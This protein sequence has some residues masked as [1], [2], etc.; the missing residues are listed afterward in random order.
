MKFS[1]LA[2]NWGEGPWGSSKTNKPK[3]VGGKSTARG[4][5]DGPAKGELEDVLNLLKSR[6]SGGYGRG[7]N[8]GGFGEGWIIEPMWIALGVFTLWLLSGLY[9]VAPEQA[10]VVT[11]FGAYNR[12]TEPGLHYRLPAPFEAVAKPMV[13]RENVLEVGFRTGG[14]RFGS[15]TLD[16]LEESLMLTGDEN[17]VDLDFT[18]RWK[19]GDPASYLFNVMDPE[20]TLAASA[21]SV[22]REVIGRH[23]IDD[24]LTD[25]KV[26]LQGE[27]R[28][29]LQTVLDSYKSG[30]LVTGVELQQVNPPADV[31]ESFRDVQAARADA[32]KVINESTGYANQIVPQARGAAEQMLAEARAYKD[33]TLTRAEGEAGRFEAQLRGY[34]VAPEVTRERIYFDMARE[35]LQ[36]V[37]KV[38]ISGDSTGVLPYLPLEKLMPKGGR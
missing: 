12:T 8:G 37:P 16:V 5:T 10:G 21:E 6:M 31:I 25:N 23:P 13:T 26:V 9:I 32:E 35:I 3:T 19:I 38:V 24:A 36:G 1:D 11:R 7:G 20:T 28:E 17:I 2:F 4:G 29:L 34:R 33:A 18:V 22:M 30:I 14:G 27:A 15:G